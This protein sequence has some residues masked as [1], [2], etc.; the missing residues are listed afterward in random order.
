MRRYGSVVV[1]LAT[2]LLLA[3]FLPAHAAPQKDADNCSDH[4]LFTRMANMRLT[5]CKTLPFDSFKFKT[6]DKFLWTASGAAAAKRIAGGADFFWSRW[7][8]GR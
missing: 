1:L 6:G 8:V 3:T 4:P 5:F 2:A 7:S